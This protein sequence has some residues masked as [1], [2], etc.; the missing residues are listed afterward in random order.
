MFSGKDESLDPWSCPIY[1]FS[2][3]IKEKI[4]SGKDK[5]SFPVSPSIFR[6]ESKLML[7]GNWKYSKKLKLRLRLYL[8][9]Q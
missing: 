5:R 7:G 1:N 2:R 4:S 9:P 3:D 6:F 8:N